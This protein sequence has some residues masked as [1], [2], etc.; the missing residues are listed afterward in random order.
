VALLVID[1]FASLLAK[2]TTTA[3]T[4]KTGNYIEEKGK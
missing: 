1:D 4:F 3:T 2:V